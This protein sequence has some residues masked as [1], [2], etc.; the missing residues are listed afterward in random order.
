MDLVVFENNKPYVIDEFREGRFDY[1]ELASDVAETKF[2]QFLFGE[3]IV[4]RLARDYP[5]PRRRHYVPLWMYVSSQLS[6][7]LHGSH[8]FHSYREHCAFVGVTR[9]WSAG[10]QRLCSSGLASASTCNT[11]ATRAS[12]RRGLRARRCPRLSVA[13]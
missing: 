10:L 1:I 4:E 7:R 8:S 9:H 13:S 11:P 5:S 6:L 2:F 3:G 12:A